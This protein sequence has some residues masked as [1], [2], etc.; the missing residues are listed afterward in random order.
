MNART[1]KK[2]ILQALESTYL[3]EQIRSNIWKTLLFVYFSFVLSNS[4]DIVHIVQWSISLLFFLPF[5]LFFPESAGKN[6][7]SMLK[8]LCSLFVAVHQGPESK[9]KM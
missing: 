3:L 5:F 1:L 7:A 9:W 4:F 8:V 2:Y 6:S